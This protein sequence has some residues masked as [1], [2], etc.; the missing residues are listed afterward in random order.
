MEGRGDSGAARGAPPLPGPETNMECGT[1]YSISGMQIGWGGVGGVPD[2]GRSG[3]GMGR[4]GFQRRAQPPS[5]LLEKS[6]TNL[7]GLTSA[8]VEVELV[9][10]V[11]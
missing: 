11:S 2:H 10:L 4:G 9:R 6:S 8:C 7:F 5:P 1:T 3:D